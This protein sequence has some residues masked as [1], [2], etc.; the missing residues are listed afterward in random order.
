MIRPESLASV[1]GGC[2]IPEP[3]PRDLAR[4]F[5]H[6]V[7]YYCRVLAF[8]GCVIIPEHG[9]IADLALPHP[10]PLGSGGMGEVYAAE[11]ERLRRDVAIKFISHGEGERMKRPGNAS[12]GSAGSLCPESSQYLH[13]L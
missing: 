10:A 7:A 3:A 9:R 1:A 12:N 6:V 11:D 5:L 8:R 2:S 4:A 13:N